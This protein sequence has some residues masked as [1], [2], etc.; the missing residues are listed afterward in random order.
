MNSLIEY[1]DEKLCALAREGNTEA[2]ECLAARYSRTVRICARPYFLAGGDSED[3]IQEGMIG[4]L[5]AIRGFDP[6]ISVSFRVYAETCIRNRLYSAIRSA[7]QKN[8][9]PLNHSI[10]LDPANLEA[11]GRVQTV[12]N[13]EDTLIGQEEHLDRLTM[14]K[15][16]LSKFE[17]TVLEWYLQGYS[18]MQIADMTGKTSKSVDN[19]VQRIRRKAAA[20]LSR[21]DNSES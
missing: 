9:V 11:D 20:Y 4:L 15:R 12:E 17:I 21:G 13:P 3:L 16:C 19:A 1:T 8:N 7:A 5:S 10:S 6:E 18:Y 2:E 14:L